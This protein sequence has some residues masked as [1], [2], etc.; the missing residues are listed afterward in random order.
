MTDVREKIGLGP[1]QFGQSL[2]PPSLLFVSPRVDNGS[3]NMAG[4]Q[5][6]GALVLIVKSEPRADARHDEAREPVLARLR[7]RQ[8]K[9]SLG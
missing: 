7:H 3:C 9:R 2:S 4:N 5:S 8:D 1:V 6:H